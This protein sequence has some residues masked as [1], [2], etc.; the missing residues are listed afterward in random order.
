MPNEI[1]NKVTQQ[2]TKKMEKFLKE[3]FCIDGECDYI[4]D[5]KVNSALKTICS[6]MFVL[7]DSKRG[8]FYV[9]ISK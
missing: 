9:T 8:V 4:E 7:T 5:V 1:M 2:Q 3:A 6:A